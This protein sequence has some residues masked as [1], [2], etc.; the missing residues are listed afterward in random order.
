MKPFN[1]CLCVIL[2]CLSAT[3]GAFDYY[4]SEDYYNYTLTL[5][6]QSVQVTGA[7]VKEIVANGS[8]YVE[9]Q[10]T[11]PLQAGVGGIGRVRLYGT[12]TANVSG[13]E[14]DFVGTYE[15]STL[16]MSG[17]SMVDVG[18]KGNSTIQVLGGHVSGLFLQENAELAFVSG[19]IRWLGIYDEATAVL[20]GGTIEII[21]NQQ[22]SDVTKHI[23]FI[24][25]VGTVHYTGGLLTGN[26]LDGSSFA[27]TLKDQSGYD[28]V[29]SN[30]QF[31]PE[32][33]TVLLMGLAT[34]LL[35]RRRG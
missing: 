15:H 2:V 28:S 21:T 22:D 26:W 32:P 13:G 16:S 17:G 25:D 7:G 19:S 34:F 4:V 6:S 31:I 12:S 11:L 30:I 24:C 3:F 29:Y 33:A 20:S 23:T 5:N 35:H 9:V 18:F 8:S 27:V 10:D 1:V 14:F